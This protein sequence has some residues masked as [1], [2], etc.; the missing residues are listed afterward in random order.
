MAKRQ[1]RFDADVIVIGAGVSGLAAARDLCRAG[2]DVVMLEARDRIGGRILTQHSS[3]GVPIELGA[4]FIHGA[5]NETWPIARDAK[6]AVVDVADGH[7]LFDHDHLGECNDM[8][9]EL[10]K[11][12]SRLKDADPRS[13]FADYLKRY[14]SARRLRR[15]RRTAIAFVEGFHAARLERISVGSLLKAAQAESEDGATDS[16]RVLNGYSSVPNAILDRIPAERFTLRLNTIVRRIEWARGSV[17]VHAQSSKK[18]VL[19]MLRAPRAVVTLPL[20]VLQEPGAVVFEPELGD[21]RDAIQKLAMGTAVRLVL[22]FKSAFWEDDSLKK[23]MKANLKQLSFI[24][25][26]GEPVLALWTTLPVRTPVLTAWSAGS[27][28]ESLAARRRDEILDTVLR[29][30]ARFFRVTRHTLRAQLE[31]W[32][33]HDWSADRFS[34]GAYSYIPVEAIDGPE[35]LAKPLADTLYFA[36]EATD[37]QGDWGTVHGAIRS[38]YRVAKEIVKSSRLRR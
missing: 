31:D 30:I 17:A 35:R 19:R 12:M 28:G 27:V 1:S 10:E 11:I 21:T 14:G 22:Q 29:S 38:G 33:Y 24:H 26:P 34:R 8:W 3:A 9:D 13:S 16:F 6:L 2:L 7:L 18:T 20:G 25:A 4:E 5:D 15:A 37:S 32:H 23:R 36:G